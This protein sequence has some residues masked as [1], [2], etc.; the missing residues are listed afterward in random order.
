MYF[1]CDES[2]MIKFAEKY[3]SVQDGVGFINKIR[4]LYKPV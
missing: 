3:P 2:C 4:G 1:F